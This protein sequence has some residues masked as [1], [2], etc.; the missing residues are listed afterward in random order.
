M[1]DKAAAILLRVAGSTEG[2]V[3]RLGSAGGLI[4]RGAQCDLILEDPERI[5]SKEHARIAFEGGAFYVTVLGRNG[6]LLGGRP[7]PA[8]PAGRLPLRK[9]DILRI[10][11]TDIVVEEISVMPSAP[12]APGLPPASS[13][14]PVGAPAQP[15]TTV[16]QASPTPWSAAEADRVS[17]EWEARLGG[18]LTSAPAAAQPAMAPIPDMTREPSPTPGVPPERAPYA[19]EPEPVRPPVA[20]LPP[21]IVVLGDQEANRTRPVGGHSGDFDPITDLGDDGPLSALL[22]G[23][24]YQPPQAELSPAS[25]PPPQVR[26]PEQAPDPVSLMTPGPLPQAEEP[27][28]DWPWG[29][30]PVQAA[31]AAPGPSYPAASAPVAPPAAPY[32]AAPYQLPLNAPSTASAWG[33]TPAGGRE[34]GIPPDAAFLRGAGIGLPHRDPSMPAATAYDLGRALSALC[35]YLV[36]VSHEGAQ[37]PGSAFAELPTGGLALSE[38]VAAADYRPGDV[39]HAVRQVV[40]M[41]RQH[42]GLARGARNAAVIDPRVMDPARL[43]L[44]W[45]LDPRH[46][47]TPARAW[48]LYEANFDSILDEARDAATSDRAS[49][50]HMG[51]RASGTQGGGSR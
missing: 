38:L 45:K 13:Y 48:A 26:A 31:P 51:D 6:L 11:R 15:G 7:K 24:P 22:S 12:S 2:S 21:P 39:E 46:R 49:G 34:A 43:I 41:L 16:E 33:E 36:E 37:V 35:D 5:V 47:A 19:A 20:D 29:A 23:R 25:P 44:R 30:T 9:G 3:V 18:F 10:G 50:T 42:R 27:P 4:G 1:S 40:R 8:D 32:V 14:P 17:D 28:T